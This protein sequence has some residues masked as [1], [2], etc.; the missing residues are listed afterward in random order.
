MNKKHCS[1]YLHEKRGYFEAADLAGSIS[2]ND[3]TPH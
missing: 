1:F 3:Y 2:Y